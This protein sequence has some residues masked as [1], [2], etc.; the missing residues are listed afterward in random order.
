LNES[1]R[2]RKREVDRIRSRRRRESTLSRIAELEVKL[3]RVLAEKAGDGLGQRKPEEI[4][5]PN[6]AGIFVDNNAE[7]HGNCAS[8]LF[9]LLKHQL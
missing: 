2:A 1:Q 9:C 6:I 7:T 8:L 3:Q 5:I 4:E